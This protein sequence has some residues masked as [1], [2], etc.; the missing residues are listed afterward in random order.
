LFVKRKDIDRYRSYRTK[1]II[2]ERYEEY[3]SFFDKTNGG[4]V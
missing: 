4:A 1:E 3:A 2:L